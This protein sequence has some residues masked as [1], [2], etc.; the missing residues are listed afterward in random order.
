MRKRNIEKV[1]L[2]II[3]VTILLLVPSC[4]RSDNARMSVCLEEQEVN[5][6]ALTSNEGDD[7]ET[8]DEL[9]NSDYEQKFSV[10]GET[11][12]HLTNNESNQNEETINSLEVSP[13]YSSTYKLFYGEWE[14]TEV[15]G[16]NHNYGKSFSGA[17]KIVGTRVSYDREKI[18]ANGLTVNNFKYSYTIN[19]NIK[20]M[21]YFNNTLT[22]QELG[23]KGEYYVFIHVETY[24]PGVNLGI[25]FV[26]DE[27]FILDDNRL[28]LVKNNV[29]YLAERLSYIE[30]KEDLDYTHM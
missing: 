23:I 27:F 10:E 18:L 11:I 7:S 2:I 1:T 26:G 16:Y 22:N 9:N 24:I 25:S 15:I 12:S 5:S 28:I 6:Q 4:G 19:P 17:D 14:I 30:N 20:D 8:V 21:C 3:V 29:F 13:I